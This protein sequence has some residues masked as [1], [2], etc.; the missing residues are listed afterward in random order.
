MLISWT[1]ETSSFISDLHQQTLETQFSNLFYNY[2]AS[3]W[4]VGGTAAEKKSICTGNF[5]ANSST[6]CYLPRGLAHTLHQNSI[7]RPYV[8]II[9][10]CLHEVRSD[11]KEAGPER[12][13][14]AASNDSCMCPYWCVCVCVR[15]RGSHRAGTSEGLTDQNM[16]CVRWSPNTGRQR[17]IRR[18]VVSVDRVCELP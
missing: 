9:S 6:C 16:Q 18:G 14:S 12:G 10:S 15:K 1:T 11:H 17:I 13:N 4:P 8:Q 5:Y 3:Y 7:I 2:L